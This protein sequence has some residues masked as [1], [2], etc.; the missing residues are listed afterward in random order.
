MLFKFW[1][2]KIN[3]LKRKKKEYYLNNIECIFEYFEDKKNI[4]KGFQNEKI[5]DLNNFF[6]IKDCSINTDSEQTCVQKYFQ[7]INK[8]ALDLNL[9]S[10]PVDTCQSCF[11]GEL[12]P[13]EQE[14]LLV[15]NNCGKNIKFLIP[16]KYE[17]FIKLD[18]I[19]KF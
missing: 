17:P 1:N 10:Y 13:I 3:K 16:A 7:N 9:F 5:N 2:K 18:W 6:N 14:G 11:K 4:A 15:C 8:N 12:I 19:D